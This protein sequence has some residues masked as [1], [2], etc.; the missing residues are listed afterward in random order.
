MQAIL[1]L[2]KNVEFQCERLTVDRFKINIRR[3]NARQN[4]PK[5]YLSYIRAYQAVSS[6]ANNSI[7]RDA[8]CVFNHTS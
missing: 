8:P 3:Y 5:N 2:L 7:N 1:N 4:S 6:K